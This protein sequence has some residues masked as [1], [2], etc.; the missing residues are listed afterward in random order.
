MRYALLGLM[1]EWRQNLLSLRQ[2]ARSQPGPLDTMAASLLR[3][4]EENPALAPA[5]QQFDALV[6]RG[7]REL[8]RWITVG[9]E[10]E[11]YNRAYAW[12]ALRASAEES[13]HTVVHN[14]EVHTFV[15]DQTEGLTD[16]VSDIIQ[17]QSFS[18]A[19]EVV[20]HMRGHTVSIDN[21][22]EEF[23]RK[24]FRRVP[25]KELPPP[26][27]AVRRHAAYLPAHDE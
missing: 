19:D 2:P 15:Q 1:T 16:A 14:P 25:R 12:T 3:S 8:D 24:L 18:M 6:A 26:P 22:L 10:E 27:D 5:R 4:W 11:R 20:D 23:F 7:E 21:R 9:K 17:E 13:I